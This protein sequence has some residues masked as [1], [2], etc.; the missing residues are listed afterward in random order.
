M[1]SAR[2]S[3]AMRSSSPYSSARAPTS[4]PRVGSSSSSTRPSRCSQRANT[5][6]CWLPPDSCP[7][8]CSG[9]WQRTRRV[10]MKPCTRRLS[11]PCCS[12]PPRDTADR[13]DSVALMRMGCERSRP[14]DLRS[15]V[16]RPTP[17]AMACSGEA[18]PRCQ[19]RFAAMAGFGVVA[20][21]CIAVCAFPSGGRACFC[22]DSGCKVTLPRSARSAPNSKRT[23][24]VRPDPTSPAMPKISPARSSRLTSCTA[25]PRPSL[26]ALI[27]TGPTGRRGRWSRSLTTRPTMRCTRSSSLMPVMGRTSTRRPSRSTATRS[28][29]RRSSSSRCD[30]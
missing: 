14:W 30:T 26:S 24:S 21:F 5:T 12:Q 15:S 28:A 6:F 16:T 29:M 1:S 22:A 17:A 25:V 20:I 4:T 2:P 18:K 9:P 7:T 10:R 3:R 19:V 11:S 27:T 8:G 13:S 23:S